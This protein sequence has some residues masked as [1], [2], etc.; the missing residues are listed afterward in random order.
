LRRL[1]VASWLAGMTDRALVSE[2]RGSGCG[3]AADIVTMQIA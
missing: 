1:H 3:D 2:A